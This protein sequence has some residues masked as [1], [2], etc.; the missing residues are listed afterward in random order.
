MSLKILGLAFAMV[1]PAALAQEGAGPCGRPAETGAILSLTQAGSEQFGGLLLA[2]L[3]LPVSPMIDYGDTF[4][5]GCR[6]SIE[7]I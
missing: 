2:N 5:D 4:K 1:S 6:T 7:T 3:K